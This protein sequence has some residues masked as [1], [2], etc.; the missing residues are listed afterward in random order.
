MMH[1]WPASPLGAFLSERK[2]FTK[3]DDVKR[4]KRARLQWYGKGAVLRDELDGS[5]IKTK[6]QQIVRAGEFLVAEIDAK[7][8]SFGIVPHELDG[9]IVSSHYFVFAVNEE[10]C[11]TSWLD[12]VS[13]ANIL[14]AQVL[15]LGSTNYSAVR[16]SHVLGYTI[17]LPPLDEQ[18]RLVARIEALAAK[19]EEARGLRR[20][21]VEE[22][23]A[24]AKSYLDHAYESAAKEYQ[25]VRLAD[26][27]HTITDGDHITPRFADEGVK[28][29]FVGNVSSAY[30][31]FQNC[32]YVDLGYFAAIR[33][34]RKPRRGDVLYS[35]VGATLGIPAVVDSDEEFCFQRHVAI[36][37]PIREKL[38]SQYLWYLLRCGTLHSLAWSKTTGSAQ[39]TVPL[40][41]I[42]EFPIPVTPLEEQRRIVA[43]LDGLQGK[44]DALKQL[45]AQT[46]AELDALLPS[47]LD[48]AFKGELL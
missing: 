42:R 24:L 1:E 19:I 22:A 32:K 47:V 13:R 12:W 16:P 43:Y 40:N 26:L 39:P 11:T 6:E 10:I 20:L 17:P 25:T 21:A 30:L 44:V 35:A 46:Q 48:K 23:E 27:C 7:E 38:Y 31:H 33:P 18:R 15:A 3:I 5:A 41:A 28:F 9:A 8:G 2:E 4:Y 29:I 45:Q 34:Q 37:K 14:Q 36:L